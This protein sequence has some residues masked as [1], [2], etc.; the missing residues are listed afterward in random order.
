MAITRMIVCIKASDFATYCGRVMAS[1]EFVFYDARHAIGSFENGDGMCAC[2]Q[3]VVGAK[4]ALSGVTQ[5]L[6]HI[7]TR[8]IK[9]L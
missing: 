8:G 7:S 1:D 9:G 4:E 5:D 6:A 3:C 2:P